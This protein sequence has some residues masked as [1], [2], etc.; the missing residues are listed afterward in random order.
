MAH[1][2]AVDLKDITVLL[3]QLRSIDS[4]K[5]KSFGCFYF[6]N[7]GILHFHI[8]AGRRYAHVSDGKRWHEIDLPQKISLKAQKQA[9]KKIRTLLPGGGMVKASAK[10]KS[11]HHNPDVTEADLTKGLDEDLRDAWTKLRE[12]GASLG[13]PRIYASHS[14]IMFSK[15]IC[16]FFVRPRKSFLEVWIFLPRKIEGLKS[17]QSSSKK[18]KYCNLFK[19][20]HADQVEEPLTD[21]IREAFEFTPELI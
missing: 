5:E 16:F 14:S 18:I 9:L 19:L 10:K 13:T 21:W 1:A 7:K 12:F 8:Q 20:I 4:L 15:K 11:Y 3:G 2:K 17:M 6:K